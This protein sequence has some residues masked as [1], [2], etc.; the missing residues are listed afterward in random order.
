MSP[1]KGSVLEFC[2]RVRPTILVRVKYQPNYQNRVSFLHYLLLYLR[3][4]RLNTGQVVID[5]KNCHQDPPPPL[6]HRI[7]PGL[8][9][10]PAKLR[11]VGIPTDI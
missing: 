1:Q 6:G 5:V 4:S 11:I 2:N 8:H 7:P 9:S 3:V 10:S